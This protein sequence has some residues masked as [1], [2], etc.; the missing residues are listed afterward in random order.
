MFWL[1]FLRDVLEVPEPEKLIRFE[2]SIP[3]GF[4]DALIEDTN[5]KRLG[6]NERIGQRR[7]D[8]QR[9]FSQLITETFFRSKF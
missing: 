9:D 8:S 6:V 7:I 3:N 1:Q 2:V 5:G 4:I